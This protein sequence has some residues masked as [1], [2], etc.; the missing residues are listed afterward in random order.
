MPSLDSAARALVLLVVLVPGC[1]IHYFDAESGAEHV[2]GVGHMVMRAV[3]PAGGRVA[4][5]R[6]L[7]A[8]GLHVGAGGDGT[9]VDLGWTSR[10]RVE[11]HDATTSL[12][13]EW[14][15]GNL[16]DVRIG[17]ERPD[18]RGLEGGR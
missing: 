3:P 9:S 12:D 6:G 18:A 13:L 17:S 1:A 5:V 14:P 7:D 11:V 16:V 4:V 10:E 8:A 2:W 15:R